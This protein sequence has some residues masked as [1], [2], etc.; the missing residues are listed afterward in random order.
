[1]EECFLSRA[2]SEIAKYLE[3][4]RDITCC[5]FKGQRSIQAGGFG[6]LYM[7]L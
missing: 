5:I 2:L 4:N 6:L 1:M 3:K 7:H